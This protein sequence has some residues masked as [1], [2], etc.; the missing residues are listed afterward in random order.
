MNTA[1]NERT[2]DEAVPYKVLTHLIHGCEHSDAVRIQV[3]DNVGIDRCNLS[4]NQQ[5]VAWIGV[6]RCVRDEYHHIQFFRGHL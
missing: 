5:G 4:V 3:I 2:L 1:Y 6:F